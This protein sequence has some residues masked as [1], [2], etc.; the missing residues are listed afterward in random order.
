[1]YGTPVRLSG[2]AKIAD[3][4]N[5]GI[6]RPAP[7]RLVQFFLPPCRMLLTQGGATHSPSRFQQGHAHSKPPVQAHRT[8]RADL[9]RMKIVTHSFA[10]NALKNSTPFSK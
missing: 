7:Q 9:F 4:S 6:T 3:R 2:A 10:R 8:N 5:S 1:M